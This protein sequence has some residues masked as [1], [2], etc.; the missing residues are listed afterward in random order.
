VKRNL[1]ALLLL[2]LALPAAAQSFDLTVSTSSVNHQGTTRFGDRSE[3]AVDFDRGDGFGIAAGYRINPRFAAELSV[4]RLSSDAG[5]TRSGAAIA[6]AGEFTLTPVSLVGRFELLQNQTVMPYLTAGAAYVITEDVDSADLRREGIRNV[7][8]SDE[9]V[10]SLGAGLSVRFGRS[11][12]LIVD[13]RYL[14]LGVDAEI[15][16]DD[17]TIS[18]ELDPMVLSFGVQWRF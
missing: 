4:F 18:V 9:L 8:L 3:F 10:P 7:A 14:P 1:A 6:G 16:G 15:E 5:L 13:A 2:F 12:A 11:A 17:E